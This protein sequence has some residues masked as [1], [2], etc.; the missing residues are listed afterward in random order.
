MKI[1]FAHDT[2]DPNDYEVIVSDKVYD[3]IRLYLIQYHMKHP[4]E[5]EFVEREG[6]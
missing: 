6:D 3:A 1:I 5:I 2:I 4:K